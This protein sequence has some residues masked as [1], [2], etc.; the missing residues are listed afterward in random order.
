MIKWLAMLLVAWCHGL[1]RI[2][3]ISFTTWQS[4]VFVVVQPNIFKEAQVRLVWLLKNEKSITAEL[5][6]TQILIWELYPDYRA[7]EMC[8][9][10]HAYVWEGCW[11]GFFL[12]WHWDSAFL[13]CLQGEYV[14][15]HW[16]KGGLE[17]QQA[18]SASN[19][20][21]QAGN[22]NWGGVSTHVGLQ[23]HCFVFSLIFSKNDLET[24]FNCCLAC[25]VE[26][27]ENTSFL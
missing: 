4:C 15:H 20:N 17:N 3:K 25:R 9:Q 23:Y 5:S 1:H 8:W 11:M 14:N 19:G 13:R 24:F 27:E 12:W 7:V 18:T 26:I 22:N 16:P 10:I 6:Y 21:S 2:A